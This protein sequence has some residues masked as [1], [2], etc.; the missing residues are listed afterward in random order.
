MRAKLQ[1]IKQQLHRRRHE[2]PA[3]TGKWLQSVVQGYF[4]YHA[5]PGNSYSLAR[6]RARV[7]RHWR[8]SLRRRSD[9]HRLSWS[10]FG[11]LAERWIPVQRVLHP[12]PQVR[13]DAKHIQGRS[14]VR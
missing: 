2:P 6:F 4:N 8:S 12:Y 5:V 14:R 10:R 11:R 3:Q 9:R 1:Q 7:I 13:F